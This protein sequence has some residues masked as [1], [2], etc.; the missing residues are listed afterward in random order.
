MN[1]K[2]YNQGQKCWTTQAY[3]SDIFPAPQLQYW[4]TLYWY[5]QGRSQPHSPGWARVPLFSFFLKFW[6]IFLIFPQT[7]LFF[8]P[9]FGSPGGR[10]AHP[11]RPWLLY[12]VRTPLHYLTIERNLRQG[13]GRGN[14]ILR[15]GFGI[16]ILSHKKKTPANG[17]MEL[18]KERRSNDFWPWL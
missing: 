14:S 7:L 15:Q 1:S 17:R 12:W 4:S 18:N 6:S 16:T 13:M 3:S 11:G 2:I 9:H 5:G 10:V 8:F